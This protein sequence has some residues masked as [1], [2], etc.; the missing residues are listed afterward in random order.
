MLWGPLIKVN[1]FWLVAR[2]VKFP[3]SLS[4]RTG[5]MDKFGPTWWRLVVFCIGFP[6][7]SHMYW[8]PWS[9][10][11]WHCKR[12]SWVPSTAVIS[13]FV[14]IVKWNGT[15]SRL[16]FS[17]PIPLG[18]RNTV[19][20]LILKLFIALTQS[21]FHVHKTVLNTVVCATVICL[22]LSHGFLC[23]EILAF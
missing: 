20:Y 5:D 12:R 2:H 18:T 11:T 21:P 16:A 7:C 9:A 15:V 3:W 23:N 13:R 17:S 22:G 1:P 6:S 19:K 4:R 10:E 14:S 8:T